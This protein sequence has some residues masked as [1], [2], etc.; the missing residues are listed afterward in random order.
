MG[1]IAPLRDRVARDWLGI[2]LASLLVL[3]RC[4]LTGDLSRKSHGTN[5]GLTTQC[6]ALA[7]HARVQLPSAILP[8]NREKRMRAM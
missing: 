7:C 1:S 3:S 5:G 4:V 2:C 8:G 6:L